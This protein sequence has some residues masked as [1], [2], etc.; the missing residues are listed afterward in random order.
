M[1][2]TMA[3]GVVRRNDL[4]QEWISIRTI[5]LTPEEAEVEAL[6]QDKKVSEW[7]FCNPVTRIVKVKIEE[8]E[9]VKKIDIFIPE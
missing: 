7:A 8:V 1:A 4:G 2:Y 3:Y 9:T 6:E 5:E